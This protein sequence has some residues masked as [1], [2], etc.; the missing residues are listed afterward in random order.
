MK[1]DCATD[2]ELKDRR[3]LLVEG[4]AFVTVLMGKMGTPILPTIA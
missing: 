3:V 1:D 4:V 2:V